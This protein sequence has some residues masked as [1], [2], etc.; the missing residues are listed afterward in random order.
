MKNRRL[1]VR[2]V[3]LL[4]FVALGIFLFVNGKG[5]DILL[6]NKTVTVGEQNYEA[7]ASARISLDGRKAV[8]IQRRERL[9]DMLVG[10]NHVIRME[11]LN[12][13]GQVIQTV[14]EK[15]SLGLER[16]WLISLPLLAS[17]DAN[18]IQVFKPGHP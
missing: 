5:H 10:K 17:G 6:D 18:W 15:F 7:F 9:P 11:V 14:E 13:G 12:R 4:L 16:T 3:T 8:E 1:L 2:A